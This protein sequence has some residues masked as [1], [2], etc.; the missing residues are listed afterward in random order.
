MTVRDSTRTR[1]VLSLLGGLAVLAALAPG[2]GPSSSGGSGVVTFSVERGRFQATVQSRGSLAPREEVNCTALRSGYITTMAADGSHVKE[3]ETVVELDRGNLEKEILEVN[4]ALKVMEAELVSRLADLNNR[5]NQA[6]AQVDE[7]E[8]D[9]Q[10]AEIELENLVG[11]AH[12]DPSTRI[13]AREDAAVA[14]V[15]AAA[16]SRELAALARLK[17]SGA[18]T[19]EEYASLLGEVEVLNAGARQAS[20]AFDK[21][22]E[23]PEPSAVVEARLNVRLKDY[24]LKVARQWL[25]DLEQ[26]EREIE[27]RHKERIRRQRLRAIRLEADLKKTRIKAPASGILLV[28]TF[29]GR[30][31]GPGRR[32]WRGVP[33]CSVADISQMVL[34]IKVSGRTRARL[35]AGQKADVR[36]DAFP[37]Q[38]F[39]ARVTKVGNFGRDAFEHLDARTRELIGKAKRR[40]FNVRVTLEPTETRLRPGLMAEVTVHTEALEDVLEVPREAV[41]DRQDGHGTVRVLED[42]RIREREVVLGPANRDMFA[43][44]S[45]LDEGAKV[46][47]GK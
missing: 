7:V 46:V 8:R 45:G 11:G 39:A 18:V 29:W 47:L 13:A 33:L 35:E 2:C 37:G 5:K 14:K 28:K 12:I 1:A 32:I 26:Q 25:D 16:R 30:K 10:L 15:T 6:R 4:S 3:G 9:L 23:G 31:V 44:T 22:I 19:E 42:G 21:V 20:A 40:V 27:R 34:D 24:R 17:S 41:T 38:V 36:I 43:V